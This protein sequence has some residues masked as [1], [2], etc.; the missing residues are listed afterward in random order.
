MSSRLSVGVLL[1]CGLLGG[2]AFAALQ[3]AA[4]S[5]QQAE[6]FDKKMAIV[7]QQGTSGIRGQSPGP[8]RTPFTE[9]EVN[10][11]FA[12]RSGDVMP[13]GVS[14]PRITIVGNGK[15]TAA[16]TV[17]LE[18]IAKRRSSGRTLDPWSY[19]GGKLPVTLTGVL[20]TQNGIGNFELQEAAV[21][22]VPVPTSVLQDIVAYYSRT[23]DDP[24]GVRLNDPFK[25]P[26]QIKQIEVGQGQAVVVQ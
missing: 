18:T 24:E 15:L 20:R 25:L 6:A 16:A 1:L 12:Y 26:S 13:S 9:T 14:D 10:S 2:A 3:A 17:D 22:G 4:V 23:A 7:R 5:E 11:W 21:S 8:R 19:L